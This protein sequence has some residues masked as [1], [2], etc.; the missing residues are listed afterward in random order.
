MVDLNVS[1]IECSQNYNT[2]ST[3]KKK[4]RNIKQSIAASSAAG[5]VGI[6]SIGA[7][8]AIT[9]MALNSFKLYNEPDKE[10]IFSCA[11][12]FIEKKGLDKKG[13]KI[14]NWDKDSIFKRFY[15]FENGESVNIKKLPVELFLI[16]KG[17]NAGFVQK[18]ISGTNI[19][20]NTIL[21]NKRELQVPI[22]HEIG[23]AINFNNSRLWRKVQKL[24]PLGMIL[25]AFLMTFG[26]FTK[27]TTGK[28]NCIADKFKNK[29]R[30]NAGFFSL[31]AMVPI[32]AEEFKATS[33]ANKW[34]SKALSPELAQKVIKGN[35]IAGISYVIVAI[36][37]GLASYTAVRVK[38]R[39]VA[40]KQQRE[41]EKAAN[42]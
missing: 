37:T 12:K 16:G 27:N 29:I 17:W 31:M 40:K 41:I 19:K 32:V 28:E 38:D 11:D 25:P 6:L 9:A 21:I 4:S 24:R 36:A 42:G 15:K 14:L 1:N 30:N 5:G 22:F 7:N 13:L 33:R 20:K 3:P 34:V 26:A 10:T 39:L 8:A 18:D 35:K 2:Q 23:H